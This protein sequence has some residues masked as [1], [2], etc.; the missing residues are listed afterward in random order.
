MSTKYKVRNNE[1]AHFITFS[2]VKWIDA[3]TRAEYKEI[4]LESLQYCCTQW[5]ER[6]LLGLLCGGLREFLAA[7]AH[8]D[9]EKS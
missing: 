2:V 5:E 4:I 3:L 1:L 8:L 9:D 6:Q 7:V